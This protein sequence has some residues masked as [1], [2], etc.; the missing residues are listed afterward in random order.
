MW[1]RRKFVAKYDIDESLSCRTML[2]YGMCYPCSLYQ[3]LRS[4]RHFD[5]L[6][7]ATIPAISMVENPI[8]TVTQESSEETNYQPDRS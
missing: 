6:S 1:L 3:I 7:R 4:A 2:F 5:E 8:I